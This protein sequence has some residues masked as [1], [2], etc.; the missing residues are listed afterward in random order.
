MVGTSR[1]SSIEFPSSELE[2]SPEIKGE[3]DSSMLE[4]LVHIPLG[5]SDIDLKVGKSLELFREIKSLW[6]DFRGR[7]SRFFELG[8]DCMSEK[9]S[10]T[11]TIA[12]SSSLSKWMSHGSL[13][14]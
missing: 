6:S 14:T 2:S 4:V 8:L 13:D 3:H 1:S 10:N 5:L 7:I 9:A 12:I 11:G